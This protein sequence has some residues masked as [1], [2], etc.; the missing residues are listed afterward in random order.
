MAL[1]LRKAFEIINK[2]HF[3]ASIRKIPMVFAIVNEEKELVL[4][5]KMDNA[6]KLSVELAYAKALS[7]LKLGIDTEAIAYLVEKGQG[8]LQNIRYESSICLIGG[9][10][11]IFEDGDIIGAIGV[12]GGTEIQD[13]EI[14]TSAIS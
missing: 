14:A 10:K 4:F 2:A 12:S 3:E 9:G 13:V 5:E 11:L 7:A 8:P 6:P 1:T